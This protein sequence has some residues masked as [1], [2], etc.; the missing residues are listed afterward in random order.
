MNVNFIHS[1]ADTVLTVYIS[2]TAVEWME[3]S[4]MFF[5]WLFN[6]N[7]GE[8]VSWPIGCWDFRSLLLPSSICNLKRLLYDFPQRLV[9][10]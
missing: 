6:I 1:V 10:F 2:L 7:H 3:K 9:I 8:A 5:Y 4:R